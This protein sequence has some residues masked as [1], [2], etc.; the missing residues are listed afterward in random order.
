ME[1]LVTMAVDMPIRAIREQIVSA[2]HMLVQISRGANGKRRITHISEITGIDPDTGEIR[3]EDI[4]TLRD[5]AQP[6]MR[7]S[8]YVP[9]FVEHLIE[10][11]ILDVDVFL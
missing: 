9:S 8:G 1:A 4:F 5:F 11:K 6:R 3:V 10:K 2:V 7:H